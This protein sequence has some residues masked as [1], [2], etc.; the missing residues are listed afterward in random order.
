MTKKREIIITPKSG[1]DKTRNS[2]RSV[3]YK[4]HI[5]LPNVPLTILIEHFC[6]KH[7]NKSKKKKD[8]KIPERDKSV[9]SS[10]KERRKWEEKVYYYN[11]GRK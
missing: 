4:A 7:L 6:D 8:P 2:L 5:D 11:V 10:D 1:P 3:I 9:Q